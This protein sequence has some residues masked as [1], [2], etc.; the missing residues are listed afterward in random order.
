MTA[1]ASTKSAKKISPALHNFLCNIKDSRKMAIIIT[2]L[3]LVAVPAVLISIIASIYTFH[4]YEYYVDVYLVIAVL[5]TALAGFLGIFT[6]LDSFKCL[7]DK[8][9]VDMKLALP[10]TATQRFFSNFLS[11]LFTYLAPFLAVQVISLLLTG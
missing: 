9:I 8:S 6:A 10:M 3:H 2:I 4:G 5:T 7:H 1:T 11:G